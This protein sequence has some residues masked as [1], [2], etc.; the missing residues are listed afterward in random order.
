M[1]ATQWKTV[2]MTLSLKNKGI[3]RPCRNHEIIIVFNIT[4]NQASLPDHVRRNSTG[5]PMRSRRRD[6]NLGPRHV[7]S[8][9]EGGLQDLSDENVDPE[10]SGGF[11]PAIGTFLVPHVLIHLYCTLP[12]CHSSAA[13]VFL[14]H[15][16]GWSKAWRNAIVASCTRLVG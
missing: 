7:P 1:S 6:F 15:M 8:V 3:S 2:R 16:F 10:V 4:R 14:W 13:C 5:S 11:L 9:G 12:K